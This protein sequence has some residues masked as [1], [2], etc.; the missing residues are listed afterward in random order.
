MA[1]A[2]FPC[3]LPCQSCQELSQ[4]CGILPSGTS[5][6]NGLFCSVGE[7]C[8]ELGNC[9]NGSDPCSLNDP[10]N[11]TCNETLQ[12]CFSP[13]G[14]NCSDESW[15]TLM[16]ICDGSG[17]CVGSGSP[18][19][20]T[21][22]VSYIIIRGIIVFSSLST[23]RHEVS[24]MWC[25]SLVIDTML[26]QCID[27]QKCASHRSIFTRCPNGTLFWSLFMQDEFEHLPRRV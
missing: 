16:D 3:S 11:N 27:Y 5:C 9:G 7:T 21:N 22:S 4:S 19:V 1:A 10:C 25:T 23:W 6:D 8:D 24:S 14:T 26:Q 2:V 13:A 18:C 15:C 17:I 12:Q 20:S